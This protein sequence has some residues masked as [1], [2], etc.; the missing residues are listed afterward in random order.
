MMLIFGMQP[1]FTQLEELYK[2]IDQ[3]RIPS[4]FCQIS[5]T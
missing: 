5:A 3:K 2:K 1:Y 4:K